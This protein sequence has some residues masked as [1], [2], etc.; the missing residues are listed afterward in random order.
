VTDEHPGLAPG[1]NVWFGLQHVTMTGFRHS[2]RREN[3]PKC[4]P[5]LKSDGAPDIASNSDAENGAD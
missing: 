1:Y 2:G 5:A 3:C 4:N